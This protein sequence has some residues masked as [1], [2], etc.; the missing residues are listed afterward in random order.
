MSPKGWRVTAARRATRPHRPY[1]NKRP[2]ASLEIT[3]PCAALQLN[4]VRYML[5]TNRPRAVITSVL[6]S[7]RQLS[8]VYF[9]RSANMQTLPYAH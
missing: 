7:R 6:C 4:A 1:K 2:G 3:Q 5:G 8:C 9:W